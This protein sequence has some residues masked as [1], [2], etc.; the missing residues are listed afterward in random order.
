MAYVTAGA[1]L[2]CCAG[3]LAGP[4]KAEFTRSVVI[5]HLTGNDSLQSCRK[6]KGGNELYISYTYY[7][8]HSLYAQ[9]VWYS[10]MCICI[11]R[12]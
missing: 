11:C 3:H 9:L 12:V 8:Q 2:H 6:S 10:I 1:H 5:A 7:T 4:I